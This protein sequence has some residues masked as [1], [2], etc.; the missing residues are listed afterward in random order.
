MIS[1]F[2]CCLTTRTTCAL[3]RHFSSVAMPVLNL[4]ISYVLI[5]RTE[6]IALMRASKKHIGKGKPNAS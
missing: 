1:L 5:A 4:F 6:S 3:F 2:F